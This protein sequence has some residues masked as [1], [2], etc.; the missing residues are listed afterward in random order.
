MES[1]RSVVTLAVVL[2]AWIAVLGWL[3]RYFGNVDLWGMML[4]GSGIITFFGLLGIPDKGELF[5]ESRV[6]LAVCATFLVIYIVYFG[7]SVYLNPTVTDD[8]KELKTF[9]KD[10]FPTLTNLLGIVVAFYFGSSAAVS[11]AKKKD[12]K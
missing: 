7:S 1:S 5:S 12:D 6:R 2:I 11:I 4:A 3:G 8:D 10:L 9:A